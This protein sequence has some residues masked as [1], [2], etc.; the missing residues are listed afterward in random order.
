MNPSRRPALAGALALGLLLFAGMAQA[1]TDDTRQPVH[2]EADRAELDERTGTSRYRGHVRITQGTMRI[3]A[4]HVE[5]IAQDRSL[6]TVI[7]Q[8]ERATFDQTMDDGRDVHAEALKMTY[9]ARSR[10]ILLEGDA[11]FMQGGN[12]LSGARIEYDLNT[13]QIV[14]DSESQKGR[15]EIIY[16]PEDEPAAEP[17][18]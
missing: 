12:R 3:T 17:E 4:D 11:Y 13:E 7:A 15:V 2:I 9:D 8:G 5:V 18:P 14:A 6:Q 1:R 10:T 16:Q